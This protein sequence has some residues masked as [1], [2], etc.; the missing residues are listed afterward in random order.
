MEIRTAP[1]NQTARTEDPVG[2]T[3]HRLLFI[4]NLRWLMIALVVT[5]HSAVTYSNLG[6]WYYTEPARLSPPTLLFFVLYETLLQAFFM[7]L[8]F[9]IAGYFVPGSCDRKGLRRFLT[10]RAVRLGVPTAIYALFI[11]PTIVFYLLRLPHPSPGGTRPSLWV[12]YGHYLL[13]L[14][15]L[16]GTG[17]LWFALALLIFTG[18]YAAARAATGERRR[19]RAD[20]PVPGH[21][22]VVGLVAVMAV[23]T[24]AVRMVQPIGTNILNMQLCFFSQYILLFAV[25]IV[26]YRRNWLLRLPANFGR[27]WLK[28]AVFVGLPFWLGLLVVGGGMRGDFAPFTGGLHWQSAGYSLWESFFCVGVCLGLLAL[29]RERFNRQGTLAHFLS[30]NAFAVYVFHAPIL[31]ALALGMRGLGDYPIGKFLLLSVLGLGI[32]FP[33]SHW[34]FRRIPMLRRVL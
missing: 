4:D 2:S 34:I 15:F 28:L 16:G 3:A 25:G 29:F 27:F 13:S 14:R 20:G 6:S 22:A 31:I 11:Q 21:R 19:G 8:L 1:I 5:I 26:A 30:D 18:I 23:C 9:L 7:G 10:D 17:P 32:S 24:F 33:A 12:D